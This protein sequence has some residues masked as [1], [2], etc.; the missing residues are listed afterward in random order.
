MA[1][2]A[3]GVR[4]MTPGYASPEQVRG[5]PVTTATD[6]YS[7]GAVLYELLTGERAH[8]IRNALAQRQIA[9]GDLHSGTAESRAQSVK[10]LDPDLDNIVLMALRKEPERR[11]AVGAGVIG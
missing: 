6:I 5:E 11:Y 7:L 9:E 1:L 10:E 3:T 8:R 2:T 4:L